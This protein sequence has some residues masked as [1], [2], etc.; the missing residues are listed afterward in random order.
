MLLV[1]G[2]SGH[3]GEAIARLAPSLGFSVRGLDIK[4]GPFTDVVASITAPDAVRA[5]VSGCTGVLHTATLHKPHVETHPK[6][7]FVD[8]NVAGTLTLLEAAAAAGVGRFVF[9]ST[10]SAFGAALTPPPGAPA[11]WIDETVGAVPKNIYGATKTAAEDLCELFARR[12]GLPAI[13]LRTSRFFP[14]PDDDAAQ[15]CAYADGNAKANEFLFRRVDIED[16]ALA[17]LAALRAPLEIPFAKYVVSAP[18]PFVRADLA[19]L[20]RD[21]AAVV[22]RYHPDFPAIYRQ[23]GWRMFEEFDRVYVSRR[24]VDALGWAP[25]YDFGAILAQLAAGEPFGSALARAV[26]AKGYHAGAASGN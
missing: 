18:P 24:A 21:P 22:A 17:H 8:V 10:T 3:I 6:Q 11:A 5:A 1:T 15:R 20:R 7:A 12:E 25:R 19:A 13:V 2:S 9:T 14:E 23:L 4:P 26:G 16:A